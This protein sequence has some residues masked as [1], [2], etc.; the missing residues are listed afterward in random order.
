[1]RFVGAALELLLGASRGA[2]GGEGAE[3]DQDS[4][5]HLGHAHDSHGYL[6]ALMINPQQSRGMVG[7]ENWVCVVLS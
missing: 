1:M 2:R 7:G 4:D 5:T 3:E 6:E